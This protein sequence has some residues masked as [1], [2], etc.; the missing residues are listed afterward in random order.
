MHIGR[1]GHSHNSACEIQVVFP[2]AT[3]PFSAPLAGSSLP[4][5]VS[6]ST[7]YTSGSSRSAD[8]FGTGKDAGRGEGT[9]CRIGRFA[10]GW[11]GVDDRLCG[12]LRPSFYRI[13]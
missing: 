6:A 3:T 11:L 9:V 2:T 7:T 10:S 4:G 8:D 5:I 13:N 12:I 1:H